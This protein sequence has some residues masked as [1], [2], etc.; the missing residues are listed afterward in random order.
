MWDF[1]LDD[2]Y[3]ISASIQITVPT[4]SAPL[5]DSSAV[6]GGAFNFMP[7]VTSALAL[8]VVAA[9]GWKYGGRVLEWVLRFGA[10]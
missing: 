10:K 4:P 2:L 9:L 1:L 7:V 8:F 6:I 5:I 3:R